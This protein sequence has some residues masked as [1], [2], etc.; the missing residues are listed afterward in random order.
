MNNSHKKNGR[1]PAKGN[2]RIGN[3]IKYGDSNL[4]NVPGVHNPIDAIK[5]AQIKRTLISGL[6]TYKNVCK[7]LERNFLGVQNEN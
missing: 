3:R 7:G 6:S 1:F 2:D 4:M 5:L